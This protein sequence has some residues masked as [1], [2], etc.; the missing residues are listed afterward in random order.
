MIT[1]IITALVLTLV[2]ARITAALGSDWSPPLSRL[3]H[4]G[5]RPGPSSRPVLWKERGHPLRGSL[6]WAPAVTVLALAL[7]LMLLSP[8]G[9]PTAPPLV[10][11]LDALWWITWIG[12]L[13]LATATFQVEK[14]RGSLPLLLTSSMRGREILIGKTIGI[15]HRLLPLI[16]LMAG[17]TVIPMMGF[18]IENGSVPF[19]DTYFSLAYSFSRTV[20]L[21]QIL[22]LGMYFSLRARSA[23]TAAVWTL[24][25]YLAWSALAYV[26]MVLLKP[27]L[28][29]LVTQGLNQT[30]IWL[31]AAWGLILLLAF[32]IPLWRKFDALAG[33][34]P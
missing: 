18:G 16:L 26:A 27:L 24:A 23:L 17:L 21:G 11:L 1:W 31:Y 29:S 7:L 6:T 33:R 4:M 30:L 34:M 14:E 13:F 15:V 22:T 10:S 12:L 8:D 3:R 9:L 20:F 2:A 32:A 25:I 28:P 19:Q 5:G